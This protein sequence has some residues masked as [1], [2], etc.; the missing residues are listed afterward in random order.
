M[1]PGFH[2]FDMVIILVIALLIFGPKKLPEMGK[3]IGQSINQFKKG[4][5]DITKPKEEN[6]PLSEID[7]LEREIALK[8]AA[9]QEQSSARSASSISDLDLQAQA[10]RE[11][12]SVEKPLS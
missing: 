8:K 10:Q 9:L 6:E 4:M 7:Q 1:I 5:S 12:A 11:R 3:A 2:G